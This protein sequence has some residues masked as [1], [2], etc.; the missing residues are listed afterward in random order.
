M[1][2]SKTK[3]L[4]VQFQTKEDS[5]WCK[6]TGLT[7]NLLSTQVD[8]SKERF[9]ERFQVSF[10]SR[11][12]TRLKETRFVTRLLSAKDQDKFLQISSRFIFSSY[13]DYCLNVP[14][15]LLFHC[16][17]YFSKFYLSYQHNLASLISF[18]KS[19]SK[20]YKHFP[21]FSR[22]KTFSCISQAISQSHL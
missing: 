15:K 18:N 8:K 21:S 13:Q 3:L 10:I 16:L 14:V 19:P 22:N 7:I 12:L 2:S 5:F 11:R 9:Q 4:S 6:L 1:T 20:P 17:F